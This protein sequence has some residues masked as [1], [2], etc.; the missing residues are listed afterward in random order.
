MKSW[1]PSLLLVSTVAHASC[2]RSS[3]SSASPSPVPPAPSNLA[4]PGKGTPPA[5]PDAGTPVTP[6][7]QRGA[8]IHADVLAM[9]PPH[10]KV[11]AGYSGSFHLGAFAADT[12]WQAFARDAGIA[13]APALGKGQVALY[14]ILDTHTNGL[15]P[16]TVTVDGDQL[17]VTIRWDS[18]APAWVDTPG[19]FVIVDRPGIKTVRVRT[20]SDGH[21]TD[22]GTYPMP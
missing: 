18:I 11:Q 13:K 10:L 2:E 9:L 14:V 12:A 15:G 17:T 7:W 8:L 3:A 20:D 4:L 1:L 16:K 22:L 5:A 6:V 19:V 21:I